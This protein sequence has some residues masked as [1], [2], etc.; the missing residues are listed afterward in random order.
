MACQ[1]DVNDEPLVVPEETCTEEEVLVPTPAPRA[2]RNKVAAAALVLGLAGMAVVA[3]AARTRSGRSPREPE[4]NSAAV[5]SELTSD[6][7]GQYMGGWGSEPQDDNHVGCGGYE[8]CTCEWANDYMCSRK[9]EPS[10]PCWGCC[11]RTLFPESYNHAIQEQRYDSRDQRYDSRERHDRYGDRRDERREE[12]RYDVTLHRGDQ[13]RVQ[14]RGEWAKGKIMQRVSRDRYA[15]ALVATGRTQTFN[16]DS[17]ALDRDR[18]D[19]S[20]V[21]YLMRFVLVIVA[22][23]LC[24][25]L[26]N[27]AMKQK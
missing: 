22:V 23:L 19:S 27:V 12:R 4:S 17:I 25:G 16:K 24:A 15:V 21:T 3:L 20:F 26:L 13:V 5:S 18:S 11:C 2:P 1:R 8:S 10:T 6:L 7:L 9:D 14:M